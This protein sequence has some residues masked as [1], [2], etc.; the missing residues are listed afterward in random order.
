MKEG[1]IA[2]RRRILALIERF[3]GLHLRDLARRATLS[4]A[5][6]GYH[7]EALEKEGLVQ[8]KFDDFYRRFYPVQ[9]A[10][11]SPADQQLLGLLR[12]RV[13]AEISIH[14]LEQSPTTH[15]ALSA[16]LGL[17]KST[18]SYHI[19]KLEAAGLV[20]VSSDGIRLQEPER[21]RRLLHTWRPPSDF[22]ER[23]AEIWRKLYRSAR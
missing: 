16:K 6:A 3:P 8:S 11:P 13:P 18:L 1:A 14:L 4:E 12:Q 5:L 23:F 22:T 9:T 2:I 19:A 10:A 20:L 17:A 21:V 7:L 15:T